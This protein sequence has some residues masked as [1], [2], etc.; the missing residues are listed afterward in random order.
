[1]AEAQKSGCDL[2]HAEC[3]DEQ[4]FVQL[5]S[6]V[7]DS[8]DSDTGVAARWRRR[9][10]RRNR[11]YSGYRPYGP[12]ST[13]STTTGTTSTTTSS[14]T[15]TIPVCGLIGGS[16]SGTNETTVDFPADVNTTVVLPVNAELAAGCCVQ[17]DGGGNSV[18]VTVFR[19]GAAPR[20]GNL[21]V[22]LET[23]T[24]QS[25]EIGDILATSGIFQVSSNFFPGAKVGGDWRLTFLASPD[26]ANWSAGFFD[27]QIFP[28]QC[29]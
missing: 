12:K 25:Q 1:M 20:E 19:F 24:M 5:R 28:V 11:R 8:K 22:S 29:V 2:K 17:A 27:I 14:T 21:T 13:T 15:T 6:E 23:P 7:S 26:A 16:I 18:T 10:R 9:W 3:L 4:V